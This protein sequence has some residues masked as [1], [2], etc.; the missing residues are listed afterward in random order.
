MSGIKED[1]SKRYQVMASILLMFAK[2]LG[3]TARVSSDFKQEDDL[4]M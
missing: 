2:S 1:K 3:C 4:E